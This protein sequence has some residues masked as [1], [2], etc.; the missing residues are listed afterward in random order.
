MS[1]D[2]ERAYMDARTVIQRVP[3]PA[4]FVLP[5]SAAL[6]ADPDLSH[7]ARGLGVYLAHKYSKLPAPD[8]SWRVALADLRVSGTSRKGVGAALEELRERGHL[9]ADYQFVLR[10]DVEVDA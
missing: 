7:A 3:G 1:K 9:D 6:A 8:G 10:P 5:V 4:S 2:Q